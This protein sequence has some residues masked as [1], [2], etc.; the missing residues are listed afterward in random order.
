MKLPRR[1]FLS[2]AMAAGALPGASRLAFG[3]TSPG[4]ASQKPVRPLAARLADYAHGLRYDDFD[5]ATI[6]RV[7]A[8]VIDALGCGIAAFDERPVQ[9][10]R[11]VAVASGGGTASVIGSAKRTTPDLAR[12]EERRVGKEGRWRWPPYTGKKDTQTSR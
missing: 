2:G 11:A 4:P 6:E 3:Q 10:C 7:K 1:K 9:I 5:A 8:H 12:S